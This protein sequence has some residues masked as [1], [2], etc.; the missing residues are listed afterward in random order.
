MPEIG[1]H[2]SVMRHVRLNV[3][4]GA[5]NGAMYKLL[6]G[7]LFL[8]ADAI[9]SRPQQTSGHVCVPSHSGYVLGS[10]L[11]DLKVRTTWGY[12]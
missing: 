12:D 2:F 3:E 11:A 9:A 7:G 4:R 8:A 5:V 6:L 1:Y 10:S